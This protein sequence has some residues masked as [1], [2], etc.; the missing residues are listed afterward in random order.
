VAARLHT[1][2]AARACLKPEVGA[3]FLGLCPS[4]NDGQK[5]NLA[6]IRETRNGLAQTYCNRGR[7][8]RHSFAG[9]SGRR[10]KTDKLAPFFLVQQLLLILPKGS[11]VLFVSSF[12]A[13]AVVG[14]IP[15]Y[16]ATKG[17]IDTMVKHFASLFGERYIRVNAVAPG[18]VATDMSKSPRRTWAGTSLWACRRSSALPSPTTLAA[19]SPSS[20]LGTPGG[21]QALP[22]TQM[23]DRSSEAAHLA[24]EQIEAQLGGPYR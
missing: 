20:P 24:R 7:P 8:M 14:T 13:R 3:G 19:W 1:R 5:A 6:A 12:A 10:S 22:S 17:A 4:A 16:A 15:A 23:V 11:S 21:L 2:T 9:G 18:V